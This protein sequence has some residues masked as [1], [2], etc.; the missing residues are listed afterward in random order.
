MSSARTSILGDRSS[1]LI[2]ARSKAYGLRSRFCPIRCHLTIIPAFTQTRG[3][4]G[5]Y[6]LESIFISSLQRYKLESC[7]SL[8]PIHPYITIPRSIHPF[9]F[10]NRPNPKPLATS[11]Y[12]NPNALRSKNENASPCIHT[13]KSSPILGSS[14]I[15]LRSIILLILYNPL[16]PSQLKIGYSSPVP[17]VRY[18]PPGA[19]R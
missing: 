14:P 16:I 11:R 7:F 3:L 13:A 10:K 17:K 2:G 18:G 8:F 9:I 12:H 19:V 15:F 5:K 1:V 6:N 4:P